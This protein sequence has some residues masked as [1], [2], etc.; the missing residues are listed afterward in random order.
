MFRNFNLTRQWMFVIVHIEHERFCSRNMTIRAGDEFFPPEQTGGISFEEGCAA[1]IC[2]RDG[3]PIGSPGIYRLRVIDMTGKRDYYEVL[4]VDRNADEK[5]IKRAYRKLAKKYHPDTNPGDKQAEQKFKEVTEAYTILTDPQKKKMYDQFGHAAFDEGAAN[6]AYGGFGGNKGGYQEFH[7]EG[8]NMDDIF[9]NLFGGMFKNAGKSGSKSYHFHQSGFQG[10]DFRN[11]F[12]GNS[13]GSGAFRQK[14]S[15]LTADVNVTFDEA[16]FGCEKVISLKGTDGRVQ[17]LQVHIPAGMEDGKSV[18]LRGKG[19]P[20]TG[21][22]EN[23]D[24]M[25]RVHVAEKPGFRR[26]GLDVYT[27]VNIPF[28]TAVFGG[29]AVVRTLNGQVVCKIKEGTQ[30]GT[31]IRLRGKGIVSMKNPSVYGDLYAVVQIQVPRNL[32]A[33]ERQKLKEFEA[34]SARRQK[35]ASSMA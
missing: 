30:S 7:F 8:G 17:S 35:K 9:E 16:A 11:H 26:E 28:T 31:K 24:L 18:R 10:D 13:Y 22:G 19:M 20:G 4:G 1:W 15:D 2:K 32:S 25:L 34:V 29:E 12:Y 6:S 21:G 5:T 23:G 3:F 33:E 14:G 27:T